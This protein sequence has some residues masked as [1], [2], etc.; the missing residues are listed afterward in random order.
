MDYVALASEIS[1]DPLLR[2]YSGM[3]NAQIADDLNT[4]YRPAEGGVS[5]MSNYLIRNRSRTNNG[6]DTVAT[7][8]YGRLYAVA[9]G[10]VGE[11]PFGHLVSS[12]F[13]TMEHIHAARGF[14]FM[15]DSPDVNV[16]TMDFLNAE[17]EAMFN[18]LGGGA[19]N[20]AVWKAA[21]IDA[22]KALSQNQQSRAAELGFGVVIE[23]DIE[24]AKEV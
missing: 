4:A 18:I 2:G 6:G 16:G 17:V 14:V 22:L 9:T 12:Q 15:L 23:R 20:A 19:G 8:I 21:D 24:R 13:L 11:D 7:S 5:G 3:T 1:L 10:S